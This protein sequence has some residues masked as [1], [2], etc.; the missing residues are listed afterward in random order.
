MHGRTKG[1][2]NGVSTTPGYVAKGKKAVGRLINGVYVYANN[3]VNTFAPKPKA[4]TAAQRLGNNLSAFAKNR[5]N[6]VSKFA[7]KPKKQVDKLN[8]KRFVNALTNNALYGAG[9]SIANNV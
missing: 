8:T 3:A 7:P 2:R 1:S 6:T 9:K 5:Y 4:Q